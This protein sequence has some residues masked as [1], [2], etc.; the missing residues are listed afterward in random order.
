M[1]NLTDRFVPA[2]QW[3]PSTRACSRRWRDIQ[4]ELQK[5]LHHKIQAGDEWFEASLERLWRAVGDAGNEQ[6]YERSSVDWVAL[7]FQNAS[8]E[9]DFRGG[10]VLAMK[11]LLYASEAHPAEMRAIQMEQTPDSMDDKHKKRC[12]EMDDCREEGDVLAAF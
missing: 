11:C 1:K 6:V 10:G 7:G 5:D 8:S 4:E 9:T 2:P 12:L 3:T